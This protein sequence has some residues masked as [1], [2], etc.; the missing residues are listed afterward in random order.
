MEQMRIDPC[1]PYKSSFLLYF[2]LGAPRD[3]L[4][5]PRQFRIGPADLGKNG[6]L[7]DIAFCVLGTHTQADI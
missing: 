2:Y 4:D 3:G 7:P 5:A 1:N 6:K